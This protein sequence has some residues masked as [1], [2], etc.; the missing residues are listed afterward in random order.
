MP[1]GP[2]GMLE[3]LSVEIEGGLP[4][5]VIGLV[6]TYLAGQMGTMEFANQMERLRLQRSTNP[7]LEA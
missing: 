2:L 5:E 6:S 7:I 3:P 1:R 4:R